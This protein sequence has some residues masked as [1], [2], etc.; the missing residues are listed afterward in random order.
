[1]V[2]GLTPSPDYSR[3]HT[4]FAAADDGVFRSTD[5]GVTWSNLSAGLG[6]HFC[7]ALALS[8][9]F[10]TDHTIL[11]ATDGGVYRSIDG[12]SSWQQSGT[13]TR[14]AVSIAWVPGSRVVVVGL[15]AGGLAESTDAGNTWQQDTAFPAAR[16][17]LSITAD[18]AAGTEIL[19]GTDDGV[20]RS[21]DAGSS[22]SQ[23]GAAGDRIDALAG[24][25]G[26]T[27]FAGSAAGKGVYVSS[28]AGASW[29][30]AGVPPNPYVTALAAEPAATGDTILAGTAGG[31]VAESQDGG[32][33]WRWVN[34]GLHAAAI[35]GAV[36]LGDAV[37]VGGN[38][39]LDVLTRGDNAWRELPVPTRFVTSIDGAGQSLFVGTQ[40][41]GL[42]ISHDGG[43][44]WQRGAIAAPTVSAVRLA[45][46]STTGPI[47]VAA[48]YVYRSVDGGAS[49]T[50][51]EGMAGN[52]VRCFA[53]SPK[54]VS[55]G[56]S[57]AGTI[58]HGMYRSIDGGSTWTSVASGLPNDTITAML[59]SSVYGL[60]RTVYASTA[61]DGV[62]AST[63]GGLTWSTL[64]P[65]IPNAV[66]TSLIWSA[67]GDL[68]AGTERGVF[69]LH[70][71]TW[72]RIGGNWD[73]YVSTLTD[74][75]DSNEEMLYAGTTGQGVWRIDMGAVL[76][77]STPFAAAGAG[78]SL[79]TATATLPPTL[80]PTAAPL[81]RPRPLHVRM[82][83][84]PNPAQAGKPAVLLVRGPSSGSITARLT[85]RGWSRTYATTLGRDGR[86]A[87]GFI[88]PSSS[89]TVRA[90]VKG[91]GQTESIALG[92]PVNRS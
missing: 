20:W 51:V 79:P 26:S 60:D 78:H 25:T 89:F 74:V 23:V 70:S 8:Q 86:L 12:G 92:V 53:F 81:R 35:A 19:V 67:H 84:A 90:L 91:R 59:T 16:R 88:A 32:S 11:V 3:D 50:R 17:A 4:V 40:D 66:V 55:T 83:V 58:S 28:D 87:I 44:T 6:S 85:A 69:S 21:V 68:L 43:Q 49:F 24:G 10:M 27:M 13:D 36:D 65:S 54:F 48:D 1:M 41:M 30:P 15:D 64:Q 75:V 61:G 80:L 5:G 62:F 33:S 34:V 14:A 73:G 76:P 9:T 63:D 46:A 18:G 42:Q 39:G 47:F 7:R 82:Q 22:W 29:R 77:P 57:F 45:S 71:G 52:D 72:N 37:A 2:T 31:G 38:G 56:V